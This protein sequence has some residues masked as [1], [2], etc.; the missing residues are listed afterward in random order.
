MRYQGIKTTAPYVYCIGAVGRPKAQQ[1]VLDLHDELRDDNPALAER[2]ASWGRALWV[3][4]H[5]TTAEECRAANPG[6]AP[7]G[8]TYRLL[9][10]T[11]SDYNLVIKQANANAP[12]LR[13]RDPVHARYVRRVP[14]AGDG[15]DGWEWSPWAEREGGLTLTEAP[16]PLLDPFAPPA[17]R[18]VDGQHRVGGLDA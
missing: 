7:D 13:H 17:P 15:P 9:R 5:G 2:L 11:A 6:P 18:A 1:K 14:G 4:L 16:E 3:S 12:T 10:L 8:F